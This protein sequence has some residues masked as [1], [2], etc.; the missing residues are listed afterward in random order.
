M[1]VSGSSSLL[2]AKTKEYLTGRQVEFYVFPLSS[3]EMAATFGFRLPADPFK[4]RAPKRKEI[5]KTPKVYSV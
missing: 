5:V 4:K 1:V 3:K 2:R